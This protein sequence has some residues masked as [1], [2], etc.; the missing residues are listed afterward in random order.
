M[1]FK[2]NYNQMRNDRNRAK[3]AK[4]NEKKR[5]MEED[6]ARR[7]ATPTPEGDADGEPPSDQTSGQ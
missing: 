1:A 3:E 2:P 7:K 5:Q 6:T 4:K